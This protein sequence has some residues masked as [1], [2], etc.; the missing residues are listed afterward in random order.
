MGD[1]HSIMLWKS[2]WDQGDVSSQNPYVPFLTHSGYPV[3]PTL[4]SISPSLL[5]V[6][7]PASSCNPS[8][9][10]WITTFPSLYLRGSQEAAVC[11]WVCMELGHASWAVHLHVP[12][13]SQVQD[14]ATRGKKRKLTIKVRGELPIHHLILTR[15]F[16]EYK[17]SKYRSI[18][19]GHLEGI[20]LKVER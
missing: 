15:N 20:F 18:L 8:F 11:W 2:T 19:P 1:T 3:P 9:Q 6:P 4:C 10:E 7:M 14:R 13:A 16:K 5:P 17:N 12:K